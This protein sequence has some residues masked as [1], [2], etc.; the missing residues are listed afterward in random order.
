MSVRQFAMP[1]VGVYTVSL[2][3]SHC[4]TETRGSICALW[5]KLVE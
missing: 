3:P 2:S 4:A 1:P 5:T